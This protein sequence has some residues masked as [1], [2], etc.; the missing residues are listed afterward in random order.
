MKVKRTIILSIVTVLLFAFSGPIPAAAQSTNVDSAEAPAAPAFTSYLGFVVDNT[1]A[2]AAASSA[3]S[4]S[5]LTS[6]SIISVSTST[7]TST[8]SYSP[9]PGDINLTRDKVFL[10]L[11]KSRLIVSTGYPV[12]VSA[13]LVGNLPD[14][15]HV[16]RVVVGSSTTSS[17]INISAYSL[18]DRTLACVTVLQPFSVTVPLGTFSSGQYTVLVN[19]QVLGTFNANTITSST[20]T[21]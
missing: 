10:D 7:S 13:Y 12:K 20:V 19:G 4:A 16:L 9:Q 11:A 17:T 3:S 1:T 2:S 8:A 18:Y 15:C 5:S 6:A 14:P 21:R